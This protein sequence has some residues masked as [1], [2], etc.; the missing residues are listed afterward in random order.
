MYQRSNDRGPGDLRPVTIDPD[1]IKNAEG[2]ALISMGDTRVIC[3]ASVEPRV[4]RW[5]RGSGSGWITAEYGMLPRATNTRNDREAA[6]GRQGGRTQEIQRLIGR[7]LRAAVDMEALGEQTITIDCDVIQADGGTRTASI[8]GAWV[9]LAMA[10]EWM[11]R[12]GA[13]PTSPLKTQ[14]GAISA[15]IFDKQALLDL[16]YREDSA[17]G[18][19]FNVV[20][21]ETGQL[22]EVQGT[23][24]GE[25]F[26]R[27]QMQELIALADTGIQ[28]LFLTQKDAIDKWRASR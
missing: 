26:S 24:E 10:I 11:Q 2:S 7:A 19:D 3:T 20:M 1:Y 12:A 4:P 6:R 16:D 25:P 18:V 23:A 8:T 22:V 5:L 27:D 9:A 15:G 21:L 14:V 28:E 17:A 13:L